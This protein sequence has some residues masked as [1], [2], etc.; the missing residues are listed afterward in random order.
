MA[1]VISVGLPVDVAPDTV[2]KEGIHI[3]LF[4]LIFWRVPS[5]GRSFAK[6][7]ARLPIAFDRLMFH[8]A[9]FFSHSAV[10]DLGPS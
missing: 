3:H 7:R 10:Q 4:Q 6:D 8:L 5:A 1:I 2:R 9:T